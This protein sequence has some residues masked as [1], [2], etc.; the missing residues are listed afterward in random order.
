M[1]EYRRLTDYNLMTDLEEGLQKYATKLV[2]LPEPKAGRGL[3][4]GYRD[5]PIIQEVLAVSQTAQTDE[6]RQC[7]L[8]K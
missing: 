1:N 6:Q 7:K 5:H 8:I 3:K 4:K 2:D